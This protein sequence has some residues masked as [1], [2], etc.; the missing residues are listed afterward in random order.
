MV[1]FYGYDAGS[2]PSRP[3]WSE[4][5]H[6]LFLESSL[7]LAEGPAMADRIRSLGCPPERLRIVSLGIDLAEWPEP[8][9][10]PRRTADQPARLLVV[11][12]LRP[13]KGVDDAIR[14]FAFARSRLPPGSQLS[15]VGD[16]PERERLLLLA[17]DLGIEGAITWL[18]YRPQAHL[19]SLLLEADLLIQ[20]SVVAP[21]GD[22]EGGAPVVLLQ[23]AAAGLPVVATRHADIPFIV[24]DGQTGHLVGEHD[25]EAIAAAIVRSLD[26]PEW[27][28]LSENARQRALDQFSAERTRAGLA[29]LYRSLL[30]ERR[31]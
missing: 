12:S 18:G 30:E 16:G 22:T 15:I 25:P 8:S 26:A 9:R 28:R 14:A 29:Q 6:R 5:L 7:I 17:R 4:R 19:R 1:S 11:A 13:K 21:D 24:P 27:G 10:S 20:P 2:L 3:G 31:P 23:A